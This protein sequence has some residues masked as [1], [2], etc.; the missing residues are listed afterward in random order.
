MNQKTNENEK[1][2]S[3]P[4][5]I[6]KIKKGGH[7]HHGGAWKIA[8]ADFVTAMMAFFLLMW[9]LASLNKAQREGLA[10]YFKQP[11]KVSLFQGPSI[12]NRASITAGGGDNIAKK[13]GQVSANNKPTIEQSNTTKQ[14]NKMQDKNEL[15]EL[16]RLKSNI[17]LSLESDPSLSGLKDRLRMSIDQN[18][19]QIQLIDSKKKAMFE[20]GSDKMDPDIQGLLKKIAVL[21]NKIPNKL[22]IQG[23]TDAHPYLNSEELEYTNWELSTQRA[24]AARRF[25]V[26]SGLDKHKI[27]RVSGYADTLL[28]DRANPNN[29][30][31]RRISIIVMKQRAS[32]AIINSNN[33]NAKTQPS[34]KEK[35]QKNDA[36]AKKAQ[37]KNVKQELPEAKKK[38]G[39]AP[40]AKTN[41]K[42]SPASSS[43]AH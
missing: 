1:N 36:K 37:N 10:D 21:L 7:G 11:L 18:G 9:L 40:P 22:T 26:K 34:A 16:K 8:Y 14:A 23:H 35:P 41:K 17:N 28:L 24:N 32:D 12:G 33:D 13:E 30:N 4:I 29:P 20:I 38:T 42:P 19:L 6:K 15:E 43:K 5:I 27:L 31:N 25:L 2:D 3:S 39:E